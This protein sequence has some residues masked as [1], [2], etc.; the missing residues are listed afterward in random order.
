MLNL[1]ANLA[2]T[3]TEKWWLFHNSHVKV[4]EVSTPFLLVYPLAQLSTHMSFPLTWLHMCT[5]K[6]K[7][8]GEPHHRWSTLTRGQAP[9]IRAATETSPLIV[10]CQELLCTDIE[11]MLLSNRRPL[12]SKTQIMS[13][14][15]AKTAATKAATS[16]SYKAP[17]PPF[18]LR[19][20]APKIIIQLDCNLK[21]QQLQ[22][23]ILQ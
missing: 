20:T 14:Q 11:I 23:S 10:L 5:H 13:S 12:R 19:T 18:Q 2:T 21:K 6:E 3:P 17:L 4:Q 22:P 16:T 7:G 15:I 8:R 1:P 9:P